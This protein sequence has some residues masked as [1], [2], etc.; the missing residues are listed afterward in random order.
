M[1]ERIDLT[2]SDQYILSIRLSADGFSFSIYNP[3]EK[4]QQLVY[5]TYPV[6]SS[7]S[8]AANLK[9]MLAETAALHLSYKRV[10]IL[11]D[12]SRYTLIP[13]E[14]FED[15][16]MEQLFDFN[17][18]KRMNEMVLCNI[19]GK[20]NVA[21]LFA[22]DK[23]CHQLL[24]DQYPTARFFSAISPVS[25][26]FVQKSRTGSNKKM[27][28]YL[29][30]DTLEVYCY[31]LGKLLFTKAFSCKCTEDRAYYLLYTWKQLGYNQETDEISLITYQTSA[32]E[33]TAE[34]HKYVK[35]VFIIN[36]KIEFKHSDISRVDGLPF[37]IQTLL[38][39]E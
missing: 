18:S 11:V 20:N 9:Q 21:L 25:E 23:H 8:M 17:L 35:Q 33:L 32:Q 15:E 24:T 6:D 14:L 12:S 3:T 30:E 26:Y 38:V 7:Y 10:N 39:C 31:K 4:E 37:D 1:T 16:Q 34:L 22:I 29:K 36:P 2:K 27:Y 13:F 5:T 19:L 28:V